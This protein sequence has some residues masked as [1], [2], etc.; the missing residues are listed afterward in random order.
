MMMKKG[1]RGGKAMKSKGYYDPKGVQQLRKKGY[2]LVKAME[3]TSRRQTK[4]KRMTKPVAAMTLAGIRAAAK[5]KGLQARKGVGWM[6]KRPGLYANIAAKRRRI[7]AGSG[8][9]MRKAGSKGAPTK[10]NFRACC[11]NRKEKI[12]ARKADKMPARNKKNFRPTKAG[13]GM[14][15]AWGGCVSTQEPRL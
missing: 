5:R 6:A 9:K 3:K 4:A 12:M 11:T 7:K 2:K 14:T 13:A 8:E 10:G 1:G 15:K